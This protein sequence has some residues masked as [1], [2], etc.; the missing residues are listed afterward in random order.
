MARPTVKPTT[1]GTR[2]KTPITRDLA[3][4]RPPK[5]LRRLSKKFSGRNN[6]GKI[7]VRHRGGR[8]KRFLRLIDF[9]RQIREIPGLVVSIEYDPNRSTNIALIQYPTGQKSYILAP[10]G[11]QIG[12][13]V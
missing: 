2:H 7:T 6:S 13:K 8:Q 4:S 3:T 9:K 5:A 11:L 10:T 1:P 12:Q